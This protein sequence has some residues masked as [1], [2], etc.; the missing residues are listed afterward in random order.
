ME[1][2]VSVKPVLG[3]WVVWW[4][5]LCSLQTALLSLKGL[6]ESETPIKLS[7]S[8]EPSERKTINMKCQ[9]LLSLKF[10]SFASSLN[11]A[12]RVAAL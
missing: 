4:R 12:L 3:G 2:R 9:V 11:G 10:L 8:S 6:C 7:I 1:N 5:S